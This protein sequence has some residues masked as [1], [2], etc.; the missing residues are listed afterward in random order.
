MK[1][2]TQ[3]QVA[4][5]LADAYLEKEKIPSLRI[6]QAF[7]NLLYSHFPLIAD[8]IRGTAIDPFYN[9]TRLDECI[10]IISE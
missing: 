7:Y 5:L 3:K 2:L 1:K 10:K 4:E 9:D 6:G 8:E